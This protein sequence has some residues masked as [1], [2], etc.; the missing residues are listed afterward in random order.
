VEVD[1]SKKYYPDLQTK[2][3]L[4]DFID[5][6]NVFFHKTK[7]INRLIESAGTRFIAVWDADVIAHADQILESVMVL[8]KGMQ[9]LAYHMM[10]EF[11]YVIIT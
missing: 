8:R 7:Y 10:V 6:K 3:F 1:R 11:M 2:N 5:D 4:Y 9:L